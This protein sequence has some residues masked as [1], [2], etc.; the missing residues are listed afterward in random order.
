MESEDELAELVAVLQCSE[1]HYFFTVL[2][3]LQTC[4]CKIVIII[5]SAD[6]A[7][8]DFPQT[9]QEKVIVQLILLRGFGR[10]VERDDVQ[11]MP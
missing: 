4:R 5:V 9:H 7:W 3:D 8:K 1:F 11:E 2:S 6:T 10:I